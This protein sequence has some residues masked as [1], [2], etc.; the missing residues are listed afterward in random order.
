MPARAHAEGMSPSRPLVVDLAIEPAG[1]EAFIGALVIRNTGAE[2]VTVEH[3]AN[4]MAHGF[5]VT[6]GMGNVLAPTPLTKVEPAF[7][8]IAIE[9]GGEFR[10]EFRQLSFVTESGMFGYLLGPGTYRVVAVYRPAGGASEGIVA[11]ERLV[12]VP[13]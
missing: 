9:P 7:R 1:S 10:Y 11:P 12:T 6:N 5:L 13:R 2:R 3:P 4:R 8:T